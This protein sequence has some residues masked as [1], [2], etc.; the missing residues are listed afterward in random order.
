MFVVSICLLGERF[1][2]FHTAESEPCGARDVTY[3]VERGMHCMP[4]FV[5]FSVEPLLGNDVPCFDVDMR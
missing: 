2:V 1:V 3:L 4:L 5:V